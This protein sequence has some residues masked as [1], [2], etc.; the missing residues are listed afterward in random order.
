[1]T[2]N[3]DLETDRIRALIFDVDGTL[4]DSDDRMV[5]TLYERLL[6]LRSVFPGERLLRF[7]RWFIHFAEGPGNWFLEMADRLNLDHLIAAFFDR[8][9]NAKV[10][11]PHHYPLIPGV[12]PM[13]ET[14][15]GRYPVAIVTARNEVTTRE[16]LRIN[17]LEGYFP[18]VI[19]S[20]TCKKTKPFPEPLLHAAEQMN[21][22]I[23]NCL[24]IGDTVTDVRAALAAGAQSLSVLC[25]FGQEKEL[26]RSGTHAI[27]D[28]TAQLAD[29]LAEAHLKIRQD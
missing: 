21:V 13:L 1:M 16:F 17:A 25:G 27:L 6:F 4:S 24:M 22:P 11:L 12:M 9:A 3:H 19:S 18:I 23:E 26:R 8:R 15:I 7:S 28:S 20:Q 2:V 14:L 5:E 29:F 10:H